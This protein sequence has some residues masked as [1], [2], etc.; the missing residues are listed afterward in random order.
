VGIV[1]DICKSKFI[2]LSR[3]VLESHNLDY[4][5]YLLQ[6][7]YDNK[8]PLCACGCGQKTGFTKSQGMRFKKYLNGHHLRGRKVSE[9]VRRKIGEKNSQKM[10]RFLSER[11]DE[12]RQRVENMK[13]GWTDEG[14]ERR[15][16]L[17]S[18]YAKSEEKRRLTSNQAKER[19][20]NGI[21]IEAHKKAMKTR[22][23]RFA[24]GEIKINKDAISKSITNRYL[25]GGWQWAKGYY[26]SSKTGKKHYYRSSWELRH[27]QNMDMDIAIASYE[28]E[29]FSLEYEWNGKIKRYIPDFL[30]RYTNG[31]LELHEVGVQKLKDEDQSKAKRFA[32]EQ[33]CKD[34]GAV[35][36]M[37]TF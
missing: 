16:K 17:L 19:W 22:K 31:H 7:V 36:R 1:C 9:E 20:S 21:M 14:L 5:Q 25:E 28:T 11:P 26:L 35:F 23:M 27:M 2:R 33:W 3:H 29:P 10:K 6:Y 34:K 12:I 24:S 4:E 37:I 13:S 15:N 32:A 30:V 8:P 18:E